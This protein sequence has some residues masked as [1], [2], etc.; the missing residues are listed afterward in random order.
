M[1]LPVADLPCE[2]GGDRSL[3]T[4]LDTNTIRG[5]VTIEETIDVVAAALREQVAGFISPAPRVSLL[6]GS[7]LLMAAAS[8][9]RGGVAGKL[10][11]IVPANRAQGLASIQGLAIWIDY[12]TRRPLLLADATTITSLRTGALSGIATRALARPEASCLAMV[13]A[14]GQALA[15]VESVLAV[16]PIKEVRLVSEH[17]ESSERLR[18]EILQRFPQLNAVVTRDIASAVQGADVVCLA[19]TARAALVELADVPAYVHVNAVGAYRSDMKEVG[20]S[21]FAGASIVCVDDLGGALQEA[22][23]LMAAIAAGQ[24]DQSSVR[25]LGELSENNVDRGDAPTVFKSVGS[26]AADLALLCL[27]AERAAKQPDLPRFD[28]TK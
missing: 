27:L 23:D 16:R 25:E 4:L 7:T 19:T 11:S 14:G 2:A 17:P 22:G 10:V 3:T 8:E 9:N 20:T 21:L 18:V 12:V 1:S 6:H 28:F 15:Q 5:L 24:L 13:G 26:A